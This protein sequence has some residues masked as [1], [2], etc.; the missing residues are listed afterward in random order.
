MTPALALDLGTRR[1][2]LA[3]NPVGSVVI[4]LSTVHYR[5]VDDFRVVF[6]AILAEHQPAVL[7]LGASRNSAEPSSTLRHVLETL[8]GCPPMI[9]VDEQVTT[10]EAERQLAAL[11]NRPGD[12][13]A[14][15]ARLILEQYL[16][17]ERKTNS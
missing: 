1:T 16:A 2:G 12:S 9:E 14:R 13:D 4:E 5:T 6:E 8:P 11:G 17:E 15:A 10:K 7:I 3:L